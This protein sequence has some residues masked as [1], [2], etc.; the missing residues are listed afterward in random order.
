MLR[1]DQIARN[2]ITQA[3]VI[4]EAMVKRL[5]YMQPITCETTGK[6]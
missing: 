3:K 5:R 6:G 1:N 2:I 4:C